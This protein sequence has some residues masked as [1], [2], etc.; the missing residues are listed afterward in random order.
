MFYNDR[1][2][3]RRLLVKWR[4]A[5]DRIMIDAPCRLTHITWRLQCY[6]T[7]LKLIANATYSRDHKF[8]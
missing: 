2:A 1:S 7:N 5:V 8:V 3:A 6:D 4:K